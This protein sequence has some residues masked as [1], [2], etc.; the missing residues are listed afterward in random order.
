SIARSLDDPF[1]APMTTM[2]PGP[3]VT[4][5]PQGVADGA[6]DFVPP[7]AA[8]RVTHAREPAVLAPDPAPDPVPDFVP[9]SR[10][11]HDA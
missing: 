5:P 7:S 8:L 9:P 11:A 1:R 2:P 3:V 4:P 10:G 6:P